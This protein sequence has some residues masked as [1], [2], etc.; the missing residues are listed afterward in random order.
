MKA[1]VILCMSLLCMPAATGQENGIRVASYNLRLGSATV[2]GIN[3]W[4]NRKDNVKALILYHDFDLFGTQEGQYNQLVCLS[5]MPGYAYTGRGRDAGTD[6]GEHSAIFYKTGRFELL[7]SGDFWLRETPDTPGLGWDATC[8]NRICS[9]A[10]FRD[11]QSGKA[12]YFFNVH[13]DH[14]G[15]IARQ[16]SGKLMVKKIVEITNG[17]PVICTGDFN[18]TPETEQIQTMRS[19]LSDSYEVTRMPPYGPTGTYNGFRLDASLTHRIDYVFV[20]RDFTVW[21]YAVLT[22]FSEQRF[23]SDHLPVVVDIVQEK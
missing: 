14:Q 19:L 8:C 1:I 20:S 22:D 17:Q 21:K 12:F 3:S 6:A 7:E 13:F 10:K 18:S 16:E 4:P 23:P 5:Q 2:D 15:V 9:W 11:R